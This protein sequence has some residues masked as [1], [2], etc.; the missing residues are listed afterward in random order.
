M[1]KEAAQEEVSRIHHENVESLSAFSE[2]ELLQ[3]RERI[4]QALG[5]LTTSPVLPLSSLAVWVCVCVCV[6]VGVCVWVWVWMCM[7][8]CVC[9]CAC[10]CVCMCVFLPSLVPSLS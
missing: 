7:C 5:W 10:M 9:A 6:C 1:S 2:E 4:K 8:V 3:E